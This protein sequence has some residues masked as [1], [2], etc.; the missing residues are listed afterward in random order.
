MR[1]IKVL[2]LM[3]FVSALAQ[4]QVAHHVQ[5]NW[6]APAAQAGVTISGYNV[7]R[8][9]AAGGQTIGTHINNAV[10]VGLSYDDTTVQPGTTYYYKLTMCQNYV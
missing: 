8:A 4:S 9:T 10:V 5:L 2:L 1:V 7:Y 6:I 3:L